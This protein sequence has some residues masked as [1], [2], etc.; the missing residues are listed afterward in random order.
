MNLTL[1]GKPETCA[2]DITVERLLA[3]KRIDPESI[4]VEVN[5]NIIRREYLSSTLLA[6]GDVV[7]ILRFV[8]GG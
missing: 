3:E 7:E 4:A 6:E 1:N 8:G 2:Q 5:L